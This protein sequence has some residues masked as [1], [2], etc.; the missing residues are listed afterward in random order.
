MRKIVCVK[1]FT[2][3]NFNGTA[4]F[5]NEN[6]L[7]TAKHVVTNR[8]N[9]I[10]NDIFINEIPNSGDL[11][12]DEVKLCD[13]D[14]AILKV[15]KKFYNI[16]NIKFTAKMKESDIVVIHGYFDKRGGIKTYQHSVSGYVNAEHTYELQ[17]Y[18]SKGISGSPV[19]LNNDIC[20]VAQARNKERNLTY[21]IPIEECCSKYVNEIL[22]KEDI[23]DETKEES[24]IKKMLNGSNFRIIL[25]RRYVNVSQYEK[26]VE[27]I[28]STKDFRIKILRIY[29]YD[30]NLL[31]ELSKLFDFENEK[32]LEYKLDKKLRES[33]EKH[34]LIIKNFEEIDGDIKNRFTKLLR[35]LI[36]DNKNFNLIIFGGK[37]LAKLAY[38]NGDMSLFSNAMVSFYEQEYRVSSIIEKITGSHPKLNNLC[39]DMNQEGDIDFYKKELI[40]SATLQ[41]IF[42]GYK[43]IDK[44]C[45]YFDIKDFGIYNVWN[46]NELIR[47]LFWENLLKESKGRL[48]W[49][50]EFIRQIGKELKCET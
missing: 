48:I 31:K 15:K 28:F 40:N 11:P 37:R 3:N 46:N 36:E 42:N 47:D 38:E 5:I 12:I 23:Y 19:F 24:S 30:F 29:R 50:S 43:D 33:R 45:R 7:I 10:Y 49:R 6:T 8:S 14:I 4:F 22:D 32:S 16:P 41:M 13:R 39:I 25:S 20:G 44:L 27:R 9:E 17:N 35:S 18:I 26:K 2:D 21:V 34:L 1:V